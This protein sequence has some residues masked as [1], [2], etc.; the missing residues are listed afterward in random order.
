MFLITSRN[1]VFALG[2]YAMFVKQDLMKSIKV[3]T[4]IIS[5]NFLFLSASVSQ[6]PIDT[7]TKIQTSL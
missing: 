5:E 7:F 6:D 4:Q 2:F 3:C 1:G